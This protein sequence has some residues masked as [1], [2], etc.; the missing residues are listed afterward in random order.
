MGG[1]AGTDHHLQFSLPSTSLGPQ[2]RSGMDPPLC[3]GR[4]CLHTAFLVFP[5][6]SVFDAP[7]VHWRIVL[8]PTLPDLARDRGP[9]GSRLLRRVTRW[10]CSELGRGVHAVLHVRLL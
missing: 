10:E 9:S 4:A 3:S 2:K 6:H 5:V 7:V 8:L 1:W